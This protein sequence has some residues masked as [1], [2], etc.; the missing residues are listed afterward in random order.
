MKEDRAKKL[1]DD[2]LAELKAQLEAGHS[3]TLLKFIECVSRFHHYS[4]RNC[5]L[6]A[7]QNPGATQ[8]AGFRKWLELKRYVR[9]GEKGIAILAPLTYRR[10][11]EADDGRE[12]TESGVRGFR[13][14]H[15]FDVSQT[16]GE[17][18]PELAHIKGDPGDLLEGL[19]TLVRESGI[20]LRY[21]VLPLGTKGVSEKGSI[22]VAEGLGAAERFAVLTH[23]LAHEWLHGA[24]RRQE[25]TMTVRE[26]EAE[27]VAYAVCSALGLD[28]STHSSDYIQLYQGDTEV[29]SQSL[30]LIQQTAT[31][32]I[33]ALTSAKQD[34]EVA[35]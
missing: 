24:E 32:V 21:E 19:E 13:V 20:E 27:A 33:R 15:V 5:M 29:L 26:T 3:E 31:R 23:E 18:L 6:I 9:K 28:C 2:A 8:V 35:A 14:V 10:K 16:E 30:A 11:V 7:L 4:W 12:Q 25:T 34:E 22:V 1:A 17:E